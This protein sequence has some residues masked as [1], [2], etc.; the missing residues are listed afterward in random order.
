MSETLTGGCHCGAIGVTLTVDD[1]GALSP[2]HCGCDFCRR[3]GGLY[4]SAP[5]GHL[6]VTLGEPEHVSRYAFGHKTAEFLLC[7]RCG[8]LAC[9]TCEL[10]GRRYAVLNANVLSPPLATGDAPVPVADYEAE[11]VDE[12]LDRRRERWIGNV[13][14]VEG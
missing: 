5:N 1:A 2:R 13:T 4:V 7:R 9:A 14:I 6:T 11:S 8:V 3:H 12:R 10:D